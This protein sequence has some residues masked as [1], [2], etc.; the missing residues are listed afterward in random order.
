MNANW[1]LKQLDTL[2]YLPCLDPER[3]YIPP[4]EVKDISGQTWDDIFCRV[5]RAE[6]ER[7][8]KIR[9]ERN[10]RVRMNIARILGYVGSYTSNYIYLGNIHWDGGNRNW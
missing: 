7:D 4:I 3:V 8:E 1:F 5:S 6:S 2:P 9:L 10:R